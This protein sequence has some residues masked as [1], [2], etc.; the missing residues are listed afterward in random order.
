MSIPEKVI[1]FLDS[2]RILYQYCTHSPA[3]TAQGLAHVQHVSGKA[4][5]KVVMVVSKGKLIMTVLP[6]SHRLEL[7]LLARL[8]DTDDIR[9][10]TEEEFQ[11][12]FPDCELGAMPPF[13]NLYDLEVWVDPSLR[14]HD[15]IAF[16]AGSHVETIQMS[17][18]DFQRFVNPRVGR[19]AELRH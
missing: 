19:F 10:A 13:G 9:L 7:R 15:S 3:Y 6:A 4:L 11:S 1:D 17:Y 8:I 16:N 14:E 5:A 12:V 18:A 2:H